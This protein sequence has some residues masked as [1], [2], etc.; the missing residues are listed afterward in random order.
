MGLENDKS[1]ADFCC[2]VG[3]K[4]T[5]QQQISVGLLG[6]KTTNQQQIS[7]GFWVRDNIPAAVL[8]MIYGLGNDKSTVHVIL[9]NRL[10]KGSDYSIV[11]PNIEWVI[12]FGPGSMF[13]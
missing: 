4:T 6:S 12:I 5:N 3:L 2:F 11:G 9:L 7:V 1:T 8:V 10:A 13:A